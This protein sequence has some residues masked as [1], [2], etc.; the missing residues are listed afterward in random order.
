[1]VIAKFQFFQVA[2]EGLGRKPMEFLEPLFGLAPEPF[3]PVDDQAPSLD[4]SEGLA[5]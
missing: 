1:M 2:G 4:F 5:Q 3:D